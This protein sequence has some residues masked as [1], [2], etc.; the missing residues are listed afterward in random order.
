MVVDRLTKSA[1]FL[2]VKST[3]LVVN[4]ARIF[5][6]EIVCRHGISLSIISDWGAQF[7]S[8]YLRS[9]QKGSGTKVKLITSFILKQIVKLSVL[10]KP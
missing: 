9:F 8:R 2:P 10:F 5:I 7:T 3:Y 4:N 1:H 6:D